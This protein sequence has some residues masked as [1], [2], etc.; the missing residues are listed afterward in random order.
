MGDF[1]G[2]NGY[3][4]QFTAETPSPSEGFLFILQVAVVC[5]ITGDFVSICMCMS[6][7]TRLRAHMFYSHACTFSRTRIAFGLMVCTIQSHVACD[8]NKIVLPCAHSH[9]CCCGRVQ[10][11][12]SARSRWRASTPS[13]STTQNGPR[14]WRLPRHVALLYLNLQCLGC[15][16]DAIPP[17]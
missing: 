5:L 9:A 13:R 3:F 6:I 11:I 17:A 16:V 1:N 10:E 15:V 8:P 4:Y 14:K 7:R 2:Y 12:L